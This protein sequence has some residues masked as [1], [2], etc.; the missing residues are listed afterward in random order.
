VVARPCSR[1]QH[2]DPAG[3][4]DGFGLGVA[5]ALVQQPQLAPAGGQ[6]AGLD[7]EQVNQDLALV[8]L[9]VGQGNGDRQ[10][11]HGG[12]QVQAQPQ[13]EREWAAQEPYPAQPASAERLAVCRERPHSTGVA[14]ATQRSSVHRSVSAARAPMK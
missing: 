3:S 7:V 1:P 12:D 9:G 8:G 6:Q 14:S 10:A 5:V 2:H 11:V 13:T 4:Q